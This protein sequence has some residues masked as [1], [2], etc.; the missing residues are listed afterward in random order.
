MA[1]YFRNFPAFQMFYN[2]NRI[3]DIQDLLN[4]FDDNNNTRALFALEGYSNLDNEVFLILF[5]N[6]PSDMRFYG[7][8]LKWGINLSNGYV[9]ITPTIGV[10]KNYPPPIQNHGWGTDIY[11]M[12]SK[13]FIRTPAIAS[14]STFTRTLLSSSDTD[15][16][17]LFKNSIY[18][19]LG[20]STEPNTPSI[21]PCSYNLLN[22]KNLATSGGTLYIAFSISPITSSSSFYGFLHIYDIALIIPAETGE[23]FYGG[24]GTVFP[25]EITSTLTN[26]NLS[27]FVT[28]LNNTDKIL[29]GVFP[30]TTSLNK[31]SLYLQSETGSPLTLRV[32]GDTEFDFSGQ[33]ITTIQAPAS[34]AWV[35]LYDLV[36]PTVVQIVP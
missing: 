2:T 36:V 19:Y 33:P 17:L 13:P 23:W 18:A 21:V 16:S 22:Q 14:S 26:N 20:G 11:F 15:I 27:D 28:G 4:M 25:T 3:I 7:M 31:L 5:L 29:L 30:R 35:T 10:I 9:T 6:I 12:T 1:T 24:Q 34:P 32:F 8:R